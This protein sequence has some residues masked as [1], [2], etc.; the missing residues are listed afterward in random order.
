MI[1]SLL[2]KA[3]N[4]LKFL[5]RHSQCLNQKLRK[6]LCSALLQCHLDYCCTSW[7]TGLS[8]FWQH[9]I[10]IFQNKMIRFILYLNPRDHVGQSQLDTVK[11][12]SSANRARQLRLN[13]M[14]NIFQSLGPPYLY[15]FFI[16]VSDIHSYATRSSA[17]NFHIPRIGS[18][19]K[20]SFFYQATLDW[21]SLPSQIKSMTVK[22]T[23][24]SAVK[25]H[26]ARNARVTH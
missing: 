16:K 6:N 22:F 25:K 20:H 12:L 8:K 4:R 15:Q 23:F 17:F 21:N 19:T 2:R 7:F 26:L 24:K 1:D 5:Y 9:K 18:Y 14:F 3:S 10:Q 11:L 13:H